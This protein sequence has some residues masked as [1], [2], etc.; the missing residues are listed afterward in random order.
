MKKLKIKVFSILFLML[1]I[2]LLII[3]TIFNYQE[4][5]NEQSKIEKTLRTVANMNYRE[6]II[7][8]VV[9]VQEETIFMDSIVYTVKLNQDNTIR[10]IISHT[11]DDGN[12]KNILECINQILE[13]EKD[14]DYGLR[15]T[16]IGNL[17]FDDYCYIFEQGNKIVISENSIIK[18]KLIN[19]LT[20]VLL[21]TV[22]TEIC[23]VIASLKLTNWIVK[24]AEESF[25]KQKQFVEDAS[26]EL[27][28]PLA[29]I[30][31]NVE[32]LEMAEE[33]NKWI[34]NIKSETDRMNQLIMQMLDLAKMENQKHEA[35]TPQDLSKIVEKSV[36]TFESMIF[37]KNIELE[38]HIQEDIKF[39]CNSD[40]MKQLMTILIDNAIVHSHE[41]NGKIIISLSKEKNDII[42]EVSN[43]GNAIPKEEEEKIFERF[44]KR[45]N[46]RNRN[47]NNYGLGLA[48]AKSIVEHYNG[49]IK[50][51]SENEYTIFKL[52]LK[53]PF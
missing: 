8:M 17:Y 27:K 18:E 53:T 41:V 22:I 50:A 14:L 3:L 36:L 32:N 43:K 7:N 9:G 20:K 10:Y 33:N 37:E 16:H 48:I 4:Y 12:Q 24:P 31:A 52:V 38:T 15:K 35:Y 23:V 51:H 6:E 21:I 34:D 40:D 46:S 30:M 44:Y 1:T 26:H 42:L 47:T 28:T 13:K 2:F 19:N 49:N 25:N 11:Y 45:D 39:K 29:I 5:N